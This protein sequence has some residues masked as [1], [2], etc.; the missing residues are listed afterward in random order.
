MSDDRMITK[1]MGLLAKAESTTPEEAE[2]LLA[3]ATELMV[4]HEIDE[5]MLA[6]AQG[7]LVDE[8]IEKKITFKGTYALPQRDLMFAIGRAQGFKL[9]QGG[10]DSIKT[11]TWV[12]RGNRRS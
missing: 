12:G 9:L 6:S 10:Y 1:V 11:G 2:A 3:K 7:R 5:A 4:R 8:V